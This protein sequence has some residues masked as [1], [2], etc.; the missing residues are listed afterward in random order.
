ML[1]DHA[2]GLSKYR[3]TVS[4]SGVLP[5]MVFFP[6]E[7]NFDRLPGME[8]E[9]DGKIFVRIGI[10]LA[11]ETAANAGFNH[12][13]PLVSQPH[14]FERGQKVFLRQGRNLRVGI[15]GQIVGVIKL[16]NCTT[17]P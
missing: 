3:V 16:S 12:P 13:N 8:G 6:A 10:Q 11:S 7:Y 9:K 4:T 2:Y 17:G 15:N 14:G 1:S 5:M